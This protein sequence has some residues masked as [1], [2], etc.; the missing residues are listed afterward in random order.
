MTVLLVPLNNDPRVGG[1]PR[2]EPYPRRSSAGGEYQPNFAA[3]SLAS[4]RRIVIG[5]V[6]PMAI[7]S[8]F[9]D[10]FFPQVLEGVLGRPANFAADAMLMLWLRLPETGKGRKAGTMVRAPGGRT[11]LIIAGHTSSDILRRSVAT[12]QEGS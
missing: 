5:A 9:P 10:P 3:R 6:V 8:V 12:R 1:R 2:L 7:P 11:V 4:G